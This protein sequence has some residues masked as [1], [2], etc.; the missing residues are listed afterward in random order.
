MPNG[1]VGYMAKSRIDVLKVLAEPSDQGSSPEQNETSN[2][3]S[4]TGY[5]VGSNVNLR[6]DPQ[7]ENGNII[8]Q[9]PNQTPVQFL[10]VFEHIS[11]TT[12]IV[13]Q[14]TPCIWRSGKSHT[15]NPGKAVT[16]ISKNNRYKSY[17]NVSV[18]MGKGSVHRGRI[19][20]ANISPATGK[21][22][23]VKAANQT[24]WVLSAFVKR[25]S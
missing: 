18:D 7:V 1:K 17:T 4:G 12:Y 25:N 21:W 8:T 20:S 6:A 14:A 15:L 16:Y 23:K 22:Y 24:G 9:L 3:L 5:I 19:L 11:K 10:E 2:Q 13:R